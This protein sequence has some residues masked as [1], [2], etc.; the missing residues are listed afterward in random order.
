MR[1]MRR[2]GTSPQSS[3]GD[4]RSELRSL[5]RLAPYLWPK[6]S[7]DFRLR[8]V[9]A[10][11][12]LALAK[13]INVFVPILYKRAVDALTPGV[14]TVIAVPVA[15]I[16]GY[17]LARVLAQV[18]GELRDAVFAKVGQ[19]AVRQIALRTFRH[20]HGLSLRFHLERQTG[21]LSRAIERGIRGM[22]F[23]LSYMLFSAIPTVLEVT[24]VAG[25]LWHFYDWDF[26]AATFVTV[27]LYVIFRKP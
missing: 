16:V 9:V 27:V 19:R 7:P 21:G 26:A 10:L 18:F 1:D 6:D 20:L 22:D 24:L 13:G 4:N 15:L 8:V 23:L 14:A 5:A 12:F 25:I 11:L 3:V 2:G 17:G